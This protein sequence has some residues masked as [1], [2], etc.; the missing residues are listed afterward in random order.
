MG[1]GASLN[2]AEKSFPGYR[3]PFVVIGCGRQV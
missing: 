2:Q 1:P 3:V